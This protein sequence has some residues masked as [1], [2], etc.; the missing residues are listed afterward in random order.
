MEQEAQMAQIGKMER[1]KAGAGAMGGPQEVAHGRWESGSKSGETKGGLQNRGGGKRM[2]RCKAKGQNG[3][4]GNG[5][6]VWENG[7][8]EVVP[9]KQR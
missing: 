4:S 5:Q 1:T 6:R 2:R 9:G 7:N 8:G 3:Q